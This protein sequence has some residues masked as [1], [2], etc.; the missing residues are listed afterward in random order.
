M[1]AA[2]IKGFMN[3][4][5]KSIEWRSRR[6]CDQSIRTRRHASSIGLRADVGGVSG[7]LRSGLAWLTVCADGQAKA[8]AFGAGRPLSN[9]SS[10]IIA[11]DS[12]STAEMN[13]L[14]FPTQPFLLF[15]P[16]IRG[17]ETSCRS[18]RAVITLRACH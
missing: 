11:G 13:R 4:T 5:P 16:L 18:Q 8:E 14:A 10:E 7:W 6:K 12:P 2:R 17:R 15:E 9:R 3:C 1:D